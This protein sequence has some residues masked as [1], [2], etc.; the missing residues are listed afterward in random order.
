MKPMQKKVVII[1]AGASGLLAAGAAAIAGAN[2][3]LLEKMHR[4]GR[5]LR[6]TGKGR[7]NLTNIASLNDF[8]THFGKNGRFLRPSF[9]SFFSND[10]IK[11]LSGQGV[12]TITERGGR[13]FPAS[14]Q[15]ADVVDALAGWI[16][17]NGV[18]TITEVKVKRLL[19]ESNRITGI[20]I[21]R[22]NKVEPEFTEADSV[23]IATGGKSYPATGSTGGGYR[24]AESAGHTIVPVRPALVP[25]TTKSDIPK[26]LEGLDLKNVNVSLFID[27]RKKAEEFKEVMFTDFGLSG[28]AVLSLSKLAV[29]ALHE[30][31]QVEISIDLKPAL[32]YKKLDDRLLRDI[33]AHGNQK[34]KALLKG[35]LPRKLIRVFVELTEIPEDLL[36]H[37]LT[38]DQ[39]KVLRNLLKDFRFEI[40]GHRDF[41]EAIITAGGV[42]LKGINPNTMESR[43]VKGLY[44]AGEVMDFDADTG[45]FNL[46]AAFSTGYLA[47]KSAA[48][49]ND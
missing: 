18:K 14:E 26:Y 48:L 40:T 36:L 21:I 44:F 28:P 46:Q 29:D 30:K 34:Y 32:D 11:L 37:Q 12:K 22:K 5:K 43:L 6:I 27:S 2:V 23:I 10:L 16:K 4:P 9:N 47:G 8:I 3:M 35:L 45:G 33:K 13:V 7:C 42:D 19:I 24:L 31:R 17:S 41:N 39:R 25:L 1:G 20:E 38:A 15:A 49:K